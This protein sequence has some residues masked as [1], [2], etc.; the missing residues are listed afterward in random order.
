[1]AVAATI[2]CPVQKSSTL[3]RDMADVIGDPEQRVTIMDLP[4]PFVVVNFP[5]ID[6]SAENGATRFIRG[7]HRS[8]HPIPS[9]EDEPAYM[10]HSIA[11][12]PARSAP[13][14][15]RA[16]LARRHTQHLRR[17]AHYD[18]RRL[19]RALVSPAPRRWRN[20]ARAVR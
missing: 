6:F 12:A 2:P 16:L 17:R 11:C 7:T 10:Q 4:S 3:H 20:A 5:M 15:G 18:E 13:H 8:R 9:L 14:P 1:M 19:L